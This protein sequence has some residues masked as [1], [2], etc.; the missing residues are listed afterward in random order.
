[1]I[2]KENKVVCENCS[3]VLTVA[4]PKGLRSAYCVCGLCHS[5][6]EVNFYVE[7]NNVNTTFG[8]GDDKLATSLP[9]TGGNVEQEAFLL[10]NGREYKLALGNNI[11][12]RW[13]PT[14]QSN[15]Q[16]VGEDSF[17][18]RQHIQVNVYRMADGKLRLTVKNYKNKNETLVNGKPLGNDILVVADGDV[19]V[20]ADTT[21]NVVVRTKKQ[22]SP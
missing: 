19:I 17:L 11:V 12:G 1:M 16:I 4:N 6:I 20:M 15:V 7:D 22:Q 9:S 18:S 8:G 14:S 21:A 13:S 10:V 3:K 5:K 2:L